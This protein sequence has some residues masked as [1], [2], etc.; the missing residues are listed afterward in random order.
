MGPGIR[1]RRECELGIH[2]RMDGDQLAI[3]GAEL[4][5]VRQAAVARVA[6]LGRA[7]AELRLGAALQEHDPGAV[8][9]VRLNV[10]D[11]EVL[12]DVHN[13]HH[14]AVGGFAHLHGGVARMPL[15]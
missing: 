12:L 11:V 6:V 2:V 3:D 9:G 8:D 7:L 5:L 14:V 15:A 13:A 4:H 1:G 10:G